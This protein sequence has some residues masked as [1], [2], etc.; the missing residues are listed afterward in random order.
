M[1][2][3][4]KSNQIR[5]TGIIDIRRRDCNAVLKKV[6]KVVSVGENDR[7]SAGRGGKEILPGCLTRV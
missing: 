1:E 6:K 3:Q 7:V 5:G 2:I 4:S